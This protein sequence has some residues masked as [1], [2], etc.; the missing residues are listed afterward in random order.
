MED[1]LGATAPR[2]V[3]INF[4]TTPDWMWVN[5]TDTPVPSDPTAVDWSYNQGTARM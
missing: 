5:P 1:F 3:T 4:S 2:D